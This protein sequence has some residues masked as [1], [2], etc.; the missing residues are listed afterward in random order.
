MTQPSLEEK[1]RIYRILQLGMF[2]FLPVII[3]VL[4]FTVEPFWLGLVIGAILILGDFMALTLIKKQWG[5]DQPDKHA[6][7]YGGSPASQEKQT[8]QL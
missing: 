6:A 2:S 7:T 5:L 1:R 8:E 4:V 3:G